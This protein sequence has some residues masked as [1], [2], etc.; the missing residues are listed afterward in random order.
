MLPETQS[1][2]WPRM[3]DFAHWVTACEGALWPK[4]TFRQ[5]YDGN[6]WKAT[7]GAIDDDLVASAVRDLVTEKPD[8]DG[9]TA[10]LLTAL[11]DLVGERQAKAKGWPTEA[12]AL[13]SRL[14]NAKASL[15]RI[16]IDIRYGKRGPRGRRLFITRAPAAKG[17]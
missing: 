13:T 5:A 1:E 14:Q 6:R 2:D 15:R 16:G 7:Q 4:G 9:T 3:A 8:W 17:E 12:R 10:E 11:S